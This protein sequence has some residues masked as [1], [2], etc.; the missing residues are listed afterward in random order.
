M[1]T[2]ILSYPSC[3]DLVIAI[4]KKMYKQCHRTGFVS[5]LTVH[6]GMTARSHNS[7]HKMKTTN[8]KPGFIRAHVSFRNKDKKQRTCPSSMS[9]CMPGLSCSVLLVLLMERLCDL[10]FCLTW[11]AAALFPLSTGITPVTSHYALPTWNWAI[12]RPHPTAMEEY[13][14]SFVGHYAVY[15]I[16]VCDV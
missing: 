5:F 15:P 12:K 16:S 8:F 14:A 9:L 3:H 4:K 7:V 10:R 6:L 1:F 2:W 11:R 13:N